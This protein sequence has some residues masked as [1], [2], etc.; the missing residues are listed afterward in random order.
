M[1]ASPHRLPTGA[2][3]RGIDLAKLGEIL[4]GIDL[5]WLPAR[6]QRAVRARRMSYIGGRICAEDAMSELTGGVSACVAEDQGV[7]LWPDGVMGSITHTRSGAWAA[8]AQWQ[9]NQFLGIDTEEIADSEAM[10]SILATCCTPYERARWFVDASDPAL[11]LLATTVFSAKESIYKAIHPHVRRFVDFCEVE[12][13]HMSEC[14]HELRFRPAPASDLAPLFSTFVVQSCVTGNSV[15]T[16]V[17]GS[18]PWR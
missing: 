5:D 13:V 15:N 9:P 1:T 6:I 18:I 8:V 7:P 11:A 14:S 17:S 2:I 10:R 12:L 4:G 3:G 16:A